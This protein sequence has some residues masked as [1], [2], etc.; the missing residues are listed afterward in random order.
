MRYAATAASIQTEQWV[1]D[2][3]SSTGPLGDLILQSGQGITNVTAPSIFG[4][5]I[6]N[7]PITGT[8]QTTG[9]RTDP[10]TGIQSTIAADLGRL[11]VTTTDKGSILTTSVVQA[12]G[13]SG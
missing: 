12:N 4:S 3:I 2:H 6:A 7:G 8:V 11:Y 5:I 10:I 13:V 1:S 9:V